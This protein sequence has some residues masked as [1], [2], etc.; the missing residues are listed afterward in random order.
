[1]MIGWV[2]DWDLVETMLNAKVF[3]KSRPIQVFKT[4]IKV[5]PEEDWSSRIK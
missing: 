1:M 3:K 4:N 5:T 2:I